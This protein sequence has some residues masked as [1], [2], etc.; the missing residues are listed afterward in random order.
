[1]RA[2]ACEMACSSLVA[3][4]ALGYKD[5]WDKYSRTMFGEISNGS[6]RMMSSN[7]V[8]CNN[9]PKLSPN[10]NCGYVPK[11][12]SPLNPA[13]TEVAE[14]PTFTLNNPREDS[15]KRLR[16]RIIRPC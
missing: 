1:C 10:P 4:S 13:A 15:Y 8:N 6:Q 12:S 5:F 16:N 14:A 2:S 11:V 9:P 3:G 7:S